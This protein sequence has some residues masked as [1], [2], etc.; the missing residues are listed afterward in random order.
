MASVHGSPVFPSC[1]IDTVVA[2][3]FTPGTRPDH[4]G[5]TMCPSGLT[6]WPP[7]YERPLAH[8]VS[9]METICTMRP[10]LNTSKC[11][12]TLEVGLISQETAA[13]PLDWLICN[14]TAAMV[15]PPRPGV[16]FGDG[17]R[18]ALGIHPLSAVIAV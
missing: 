8:A 17:I 12:D 7:W 11:A 18:S 10:D 16:K 3:G 13:L 9:R 5:D 6:Q 4:G 14:T 2:L 15:C 1:S